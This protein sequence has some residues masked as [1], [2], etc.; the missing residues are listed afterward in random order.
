[1]AALW[2]TH[3]RVMDEVSVNLDVSR[4]TVAAPARIEQPLAQEESRLGLNWASW[5]GRFTNPKG[6]QSC[7]LAAP[8]PQLPRRSDLGLCPKSQYNENHGNQEIRSDSGFDASPVVRRT[9]SSR[10]RANTNRPPLTQPLRNGGQ[11][12]LG[13]QVQP[14][15]VVDDDSDALNAQLAGHDL[16]HGQRRV[17]RAKEPSVVEVE[18]L[19]QNRVALLAETDCLLSSGCVGFGLQ[20]EG[21]SNGADPKDAELPVGE[22]LGFGDDLMGEV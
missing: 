11:V 1:M 22:P 2:P 9:P 20:V 16:R 12:R 21:L 13:D 6:C 14:H 19:Q 4:S 10:G 8:A 18:A 15:Q 17:R 5:G 7:V 3:G